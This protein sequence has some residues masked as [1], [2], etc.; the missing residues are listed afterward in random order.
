[1]AEDSVM[2]EWGEHDIVTITINRPAALN[3]LT[4]SMIKELCRVFKALRL[5]NRAKAIILTGAGR[6][7]CAGV[8][9]RLCSVTET[10]PFTRQC[11]SAE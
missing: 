4:V 8:V 5:E 6:A 1:M 10:R 3:A 2:V 9:S 7:F 11:Y